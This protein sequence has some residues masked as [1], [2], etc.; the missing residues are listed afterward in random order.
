M[1]ND[2]FRSK[3]AKNLKVESLPHSDGQ[4]PNTSAIHSPL[5]SIKNTNQLNRFE[6]QQINQ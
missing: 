5:K 4:I 3:L 6:S 2:F 1:T